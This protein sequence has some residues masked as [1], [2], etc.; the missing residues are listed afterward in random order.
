MRKSFEGKPV[1]G[2][3][4][5]NGKLFIFSELYYPDD[6][7]TGYIL[8]RIAEGLAKS[9]E[10]H[11]LCGP[12]NPHGRIAGES[13]G[14]TRNGVTIERC[15][16]TA[17]NKNSD[18]LRLVNLLTVSFSIFWKALRRLSAGNSV[19]VVTNP[20]T[21]PF[22]ALAASRLRS[23]RCFLLIHDVF[24]ESLVAAGMIRQ[25]GI[26]DRFLTWLYLKL[27]LGVDRIIVLGRDVHQLISRKLSSGDNRVQ[28][29]TNWA[30]V[31]EILLGN[32]GD[33][34][35]RKKLSLT[36]KFVVQYS[37]NI[38]RM[39]GLDALLGAALKV[40][41]REDIHF[42]FVGTG[43]RKQWL[44]SKAKEYEL[45]NVTFLPPQPR[46]MLGDILNVADVGVVSFI[47]GMAGV[48]VPSK[49]YNIMAVGKPI[50]AM[51]DQGSEAATVIQEEEIGWVVPPGQAAQL[52]EVIQQACADPRR[53]TKM[54][55]R[56]RVAAEQKYSFQTVMES[57]RK[58][59]EQA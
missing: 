32:G 43:A 7:A 19:L 59:L 13:A 20:P 29:I 50:I 37:G 41:Q 33:N 9:Y 28:V 10:V 45:T 58:L 3:S 5:M 15:S 53:L 44:E 8:T 52:A 18:L 4:E 11:V 46:N 36:K 31:D 57:Y 47:P 24:P 25:G 1:D 35:L 51:V 16:G 2:S 55:K 54:G 12:L 39:H 42:L 21:L 49:M 27:Y 6:S 38:G 26:M 30:D 56:A 48:S 34:Q 40:R 22:V 14:K 23:A 17:L